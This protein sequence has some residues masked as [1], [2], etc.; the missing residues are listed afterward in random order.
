MVNDVHH[1]WTHSNY[2]NG[3]E[4]VPVDPVL[5]NMLLVACGL[6]HAHPRHPD[7]QQRHHT[8]PCPHQT[9]SVASERERVC[10]G[11]PWAAGLW[12][13][14]A[15][16]QHEQP[17]PNVHEARAIGLSLGKPPREDGEVHS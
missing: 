16:G 8:P 5:C 13:G 7:D 15:V 9:A 10:R 4:V 12:G 6:H 3:E 2:C 14:D 17:H 1:F 11:W